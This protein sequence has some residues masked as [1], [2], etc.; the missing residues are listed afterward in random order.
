MKL[1][2]LQTRVL[3]ESIANEIN[4]KIYNKFLKDKK[5]A[6]NKTL[7][8]PKYVKA[9]KDYNK[10]MDDL[11]VPKSHYRRFDEK[12]LY[13]FATTNIKLLPKICATKIY[14]A[15]VLKSINTTDLEELKSSVIKMFDI[16]KPNE[17]I[18]S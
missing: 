3:A 7:K 11:K 1:T 4:Q 8:N 15:L 14:D 10:V 13:E 12:S 17:K 5:E 18:R 16:V 9:L 6:W 2:N